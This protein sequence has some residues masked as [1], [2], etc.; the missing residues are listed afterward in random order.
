LA[1][2]LPLVTLNVKDFKDFKDFAK[3]EGLTLLSI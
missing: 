2:E 1:Y 3:R